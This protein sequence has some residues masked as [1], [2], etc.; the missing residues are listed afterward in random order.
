[1]DPVAAIGVYFC[2]VLLGIYLLVRF[3][4]NRWDDD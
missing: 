1:M 3:L 2:V 4:G